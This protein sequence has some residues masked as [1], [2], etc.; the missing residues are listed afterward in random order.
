MMTTPTKWI[1]TRA[2]LL[3]MTKQSAQILAMTNQL[4]ILNVAKNPQT[5]I[6]VWIATK[7]LANFLAMT[8]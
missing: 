5:T 1:A 2:N 8:T 7:I 4:V 3:A 6:K